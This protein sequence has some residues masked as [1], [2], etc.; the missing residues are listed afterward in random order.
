MTQQIQVLRETLISQLSGIKEDN[1]SIAGIAINRRKL[2][3]TLKLQ[4]QTDADIL[5]IEYGNVS[6]TDKYKPQYDSRLRNDTWHESK[7]EN[8]PC[9]QISCNHT[10]MRFLNKPKVKG[11]NNELI[12]IIPLNFVDRQDYRPPVL[13][14]AL[15]DIPEL[16]NAL[17]FTLPCVATEQTRPVLNCVLFESVKGKIRLVS[18]DGFR[19]AIAPLKATDIK[20]D[21]ILIHMNDCTRLLT[22]LKALK[23]MGKGRN[24]SYPDLYFNSDKKAITFS[25]ETNNITLTKQDY[26]YPDY[27][28]VIPKD[29]NIIEFNADDLLQAVQSISYIAKQNGD[30]IRLEFYH[31]KPAGKIVLSA[32]H[33]SYDGEQVSNVECLANVS[34]NCKIA[35]NYN[36]LLDVLKHF[37]QSVIKLSV[38]TPSSPMM[39]HLPNENTAVIM[40]MFVQW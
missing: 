1:I 26:Q 5:N 14:G 32:K 33:D 13:S 12:N 4:T 22:F 15:I 20:E 21:T 25:T 37:K 40:P 18:A 24:K 39:L 34:A 2:L 7:V 29:G 36:F 30:I 23:P 9:I 31:G 28:K 11:W 10:T 17:N 6:W 8:Q 3:D 16:L 27:S 38:T 19:I 35:V